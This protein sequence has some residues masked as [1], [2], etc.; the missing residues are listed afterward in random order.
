[1]NK[2]RVVYNMPAAEYHA[3]PGLSHSAMKHLAISPYRFWH[4]TMNPDREPEEPT[5]FQIFGQALHS[6]TLDE[7][8]VFDAKFCCEYIA[9]EGALDKSDEI[10]QW[11][12]DKGGA[13]KG[14]VKSA[15][16]GWIDQAIAIDPGVVIVEREKA[17]HFAQNQ[18]K[19]IIGAEDWQRLSECTQ[20]LAREPEFQRLRKGGKT[21]VS[22]F[23]T[24]PDTGVALKAR[25]DCVTAT[26]TLDPKTFSSKGKTIDRAVCDAI[27]YEGYNRQGWLYT[28]IRNLA[29]EGT[30]D[31]VN[32][33]IE[34][35]QPHE[36]RIKR[37]TRNDPTGH[38]NLYWSVARIEVQRLIRLYA[39]CRAKFGDKPWRTDANI[40]TLQDADIP[41]L[42]Y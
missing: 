30:P 37:L 11:I 41:A 26:A 39:E 7:P 38:E 14:T 27:Y 19:T 42:A 2:P 23:V 12:K 28:Y 4:M 29:G 18:G 32:L 33:F 35:E 3:A 9:P 1:V 22:Y 20:A 6:A 10:K 8:E 36:V 31:W 24:D 15:P 34:S 40:E 25:M 16:G 13:P 5:P 17:R 21:E